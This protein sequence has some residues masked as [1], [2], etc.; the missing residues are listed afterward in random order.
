[1]LELERVEGIGRGLR[2][3]RRVDRPRRR[4][5][6]LAAFC[7]S[8]SGS[9]P[10]SGAPHR[11]APTLGARW[12]S[13]SSSPQTVERVRRRRAERGRLYGLRGRDGRVA[14]TQ[15]TWRYAVGESH[16][17]FAQTINLAKKYVVSS[18]LEQV[19]WNAELVGG[20][21]GK[22]VQRLKRES[23]HTPIVHEMSGDGTRCLVDRSSRG[24]SVFS[25]SWRRRR[26]ARPRCV[27]NLPRHSECR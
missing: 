16:R 10:G 27:G 12:P 5:D 6:P 20:D 19:D 25:C 8:S 23:A 18:T 9:R 4:R 13:P 3:H 11:S 2:V 24:G 1:V 7:R 15:W 22:A 21:L 14:P 17:S 26:D